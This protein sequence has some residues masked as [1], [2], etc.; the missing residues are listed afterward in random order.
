[1][2]VSYFLESMTDRTFRAVVLV[3]RDQDFLVHATASARPPEV[4]GARSRSFG[5]GR[6]AIKC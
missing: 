6:Q 5:F 2:E 4:G 3:G 1:M